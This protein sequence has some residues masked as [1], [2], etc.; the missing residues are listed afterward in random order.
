MKMTIVLDLLMQPVSFAERLAHEPRL[1]A[2][3]RVAHVALDFRLGDERGNGVHDD[4]VDCAAA[5]E[6]LGDLQRLLAG[7]RLGDVEVVHLYADR[8]RIDGVERVLRVDE[9]GG[10]ADLLRLGDD[11]Q[12]DG[13]FAGG[14]RPEDF[15]N[16]AA[17]NS[18]DAERIVQRQ[19]TRRDGCNRRAGCRVAEFHD[20]ALAKLLFDLTEGDLQCFFFFD[21][22]GSPFDNDTH[23]FEY[24]IWGILSTQ[25]SKRGTNRYKNK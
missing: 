17:R 23:V 3:V 7:I 20:R 1:Q 13:G 22:V 4:D 9:R 25:M 12:R 6:R 8:F 14:F 21:H 15:N 11:M 16:T 18:A 24:C 19:A 5:H 2:D 10:S